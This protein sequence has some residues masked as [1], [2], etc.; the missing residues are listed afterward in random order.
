MERDPHGL[1]GRDLVGPDVPPLEQPYAD[2]LLITGG[3]ARMILPLSAGGIAPA[4]ISGKHAAKTLIASNG[5]PA[6]SDSLTAY[7]DALEPLYSRIREKWD[8]RSELV[9]KEGGVVGGRPAR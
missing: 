1:A 3:A 8:F 7:R 9:R 6:T 4:A 5:R 2:G